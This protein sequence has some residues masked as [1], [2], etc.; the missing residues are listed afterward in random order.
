MAL[1][2]STKTLA[3]GSYDDKIIF[4]YKMNAESKFVLSQKI[5]SGDKLPWTNYGSSFGCSVA[6][7]GNYLVVG[8]R[9]ETVNAL[10]YAG[11]IYNY[12]RKSA[13]TPFS[14]KQRILST[15]GPGQFNIPINMSASRPSVLVVGA[16]LCFLSTFVNEMST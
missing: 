6:V 12:E 3:V 13:N 4:V 1:D 5:T 15:F 16:K 7:L 14:F 10:Y 11:G 2:M 9:H 8:A